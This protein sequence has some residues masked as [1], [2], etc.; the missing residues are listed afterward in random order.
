[1]VAT[2]DLSAADIATRRAGSPIED[3]GPTGCHT[4]GGLTVAELIAKIGGSTAARPRRHHAAPDP[5]LPEPDPEL[6]TDGHDDGYDAYPVPASPAYA[7]AVPDLEDVRPEPRVRGAAE[8][9]TV[10]PKTPRRTRPAPI[11]D[12]RRRL[13][14]PT[15]SA[16]RSRTADATR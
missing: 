16:S 1:M 2:A 12:A 3:G 8:Q 9:T 5:D 6:P 13:D 4:D 15:T 10:L 7:Y 11:V 14:D